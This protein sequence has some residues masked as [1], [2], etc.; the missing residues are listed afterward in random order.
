MSW[1]SNLRWLLPLLVMVGIF[2]A[3]NTPARSIPDFGPVD[4]IV[5]KA[6]H[7]LGYALL[8]SAYWY[9]LGFKKNRNWVALLLAILYAL[10]DEF[11][12]SFI[13]GRHPSL[14][15]VFA[16]DGGGAA[17]ALLLLTLW[18]LRTAFSKKT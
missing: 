8:A 7:M 5:K 15:D 3:S 1:K 10:T 11:H 13:P 2:F 9:A 12:Q 6:G 16:F 4:V 14:V 18:Q 17:L